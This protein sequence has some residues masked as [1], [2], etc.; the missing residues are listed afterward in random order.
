MEAHKKQEAKPK[1][2]M[3]VTSG[4]A[5]LAAM[6]RDHVESGTNEKL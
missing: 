1:T 2:S 5:N 4:L 6:P 3:R